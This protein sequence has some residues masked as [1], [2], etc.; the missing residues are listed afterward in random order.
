MRWRS[1]LRGSRC[2]GRRGFGGCGRVLGALVRLSGWR[3]NEEGYFLMRFL[4]LGLGDRE[5]VAKWKETH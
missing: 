1:A 2:G 3:G 5:L 4:L